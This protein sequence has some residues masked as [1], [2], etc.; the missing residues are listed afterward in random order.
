MLRRNTVRRQ[1]GHLLPT[2]LLAAL[3][4]CDQPAPV[5]PDGTPSAAM[6]VSGVP[7]T[8]AERI[9][10]QYIVVFKPDVRDVPSLADALTRAQGGTRLHTYQ[11][12]IKGFAARLSAQAAQALTRN[13]NVASVEQD[14]VRY[15]TETVVQNGATWGLDRID[16]RIVGTPAGTELDTNRATFRTARNFFH[17]VCSVIRIHVHERPD[18]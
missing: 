1:P 12:A 13:P 4:G 15:G 6:R 2:L 9:P 18:S 16:Q 7:P 5:A 8:A 14:V 11:H 10:D 3:A 17:R